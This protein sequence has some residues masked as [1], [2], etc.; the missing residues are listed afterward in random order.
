V[1][2]LDINDLLGREPVKPNGLLLNRKTCNKTVLVTG[3]GGSIG[4]ELCR[5]I[6]KNQPKRLLLIDSSEFALYQI[7][8]EIQN[9]L[10]E[11]QGSP[12][13]GIEVIPL[14]ASV[15]DEVRMH[16][17][18]DTWKPHTVYHAAAYKHVPLVEQN[19]AEGV[20]NNVWGTKAKCVQKPPFKTECRTLF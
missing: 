14:L 15:C 17:I 19:P 8:K 20:R 3:A 5:Q 2:E 16:E 4:S 7:H 13:R 10:N 9:V 18:M 6:L 11:Y 12:E 1:R